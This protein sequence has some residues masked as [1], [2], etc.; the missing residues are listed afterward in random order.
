MI[1]KSQ[2]RIFL[3]KII[4]SSGFKDSKA[5]QNLLQYIVEHSDND[6]GPK[7]ITIATEVFGRDANFDTQSNPFVRVHIHN[8]RKKLET[9]YLTEGKDDKVKLVIPKGHYSATFLPQDKKTLYR[10]QK[11][12]IFIS[13]FLIITSALNFIFVGILLSLRNNNSKLKQELK[14]YQMP[15]ANNLIWSELSDENSHTLIIFG[16][17]F[18]FYEFDDEFGRFR[19]VR[20]HY[21]NSIEE[22][23]EY[24]DRNKTRKIDTGRALPQSI[25]WHIISRLYDI[26]QIFYSAHLKLNLKL[27]YEF[28]WEDMQT[29]NIIF[30]GQTKSLYKLKNI[31]NNLPIRYNLFPPEV[32]IQ[33]TLGNNINEFYLMKTD[34]Y[35]NDYAIIT[36][37]PGPN[38]HIIFL[39]IGS[40][41]F[42]VEGA[43]KYLTDPTH[44]V[45]LTHYMENKYG[46]TLKFF[47][48]LLSVKGERYTMFDVELIECCKID[49]DSK[50]Y[51]FGTTIDSTSGE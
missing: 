34:L 32:I 18:H 4:A 5:D 42:G 17:L 20:D 46:E 35:K 43:V 9:Y 24:I 27:S 21:I 14:L 19:S 22:L 25:G 16:N 29:S 49:E 50:P 37:L 11:K 39:I 40:D 41:S 36:K 48:I 2:K 51:L 15:V 30:I 1:K 45:E 8:L 12:F 3:K 6:L 28:D 26:F 47:E 10:I 23:N 7:E 33:D 13:S 44:L 38:N 31:F